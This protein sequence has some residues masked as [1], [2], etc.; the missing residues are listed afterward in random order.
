M[1]TVKYKILQPVLKGSRLEVLL[2]HV[3]PRESEVKSALVNSTKP[4]HP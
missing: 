4:P 3:G 2:R 1:V